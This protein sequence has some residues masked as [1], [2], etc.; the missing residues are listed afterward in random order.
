MADAALD[1]KLSHREAW[2]FVVRE[3][4]LAIVLVPLGW[5][6]MLVFAVPYGLTAG[7]AK[8]SKDMDVTATMK[9]LGGIAI[10]GA[11]I[12][13]V[14]AA[15][16]WLW[17]AAWGVASLVLLPALTVAGLFAVERESSAWQTARSWLAVRSAHATT[18]NALRRRRAELAVVLED[19]YETLSL[20]R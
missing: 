20:K 13:L 10:Y 14:S 3:L 4:P 11:W 2:L 8:L 6:A 15:I 19:I 17:G 7:A 5:T 16:G 18:T 12:G 9:V 1:W